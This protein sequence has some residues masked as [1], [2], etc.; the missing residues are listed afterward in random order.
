MESQHDRLP[1]PSAEAIAAWPAVLDQQKLNR[2]RATIEEEIAK[3]EVQAAALRSKLLTGHTAESTGAWSNMSDE[4]RKALEKREQESRNRILGR[5]GSLGVGEGQMISAQY[6]HDV[7]MEMSAGFTRYHTITLAR[8]AGVYCL[9]HHVAPG[10]TEYL[11]PTGR[12][13]AGHPRA[14]AYLLPEKAGKPLVAIRH[15]EW[16]DLKDIRVQDSRPID[17]LHVGIDSHI[18]KLEVYELAT[19]ALQLLEGRQP[20]PVFDSR[21]RITPSQVES[22][23]TIPVDADYSVVV[24]AV[25]DRPD[26]LGAPLTL[27]SIRLQHLED[28]ELQ[29]GYTI[30]AKEL[31]VSPGGIDRQTAAEALQGARQMIQIASQSLTNNPGK[32]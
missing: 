29:P 9:V 31:N 22:T 27:R 6:S 16:R 24:T 15:G 21:G 20:K 7:E 12:S 2:E 13:Y 17:W 25:Y 11:S 28:G 4:D 8:Q 19:G 23:N 30:D 3:L 1:L 14:E 32:E 18:N 26:I 5:L 10:N